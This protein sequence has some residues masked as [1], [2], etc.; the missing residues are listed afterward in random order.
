MVVVVKLGRRRGRGGLGVCSH[1]RLLERGTVAVL[2]SGA[3]RKGE[4]EN[5][6]LLLRRRKSCCCV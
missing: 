4:K 3:A 6:L 2:R 5:K 1:R